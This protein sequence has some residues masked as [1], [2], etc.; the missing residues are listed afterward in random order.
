MFAAFQ[1]N[2]GVILDML[3]GHHQRPRARALMRVIRAGSKRVQYVHGVVTRILV[4]QTLLL[5]VALLPQEGINAEPVAFFGSAQITDLIAFLDAL[6]RAIDHGARCTL[7]V[8][9]RIDTGSWW[10]DFR[11]RGGAEIWVAG[12]LEYL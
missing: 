1:F 11:V 12:D 2:H 3:R 8:S 6:I 9:C 4:Q 7:F 10:I 5:L